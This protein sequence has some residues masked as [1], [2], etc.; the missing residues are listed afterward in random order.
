[1]GRAGSG[2]QSGES[3]KPISNKKL[4]IKHA[5]QA[6]AKMGYKL[7]SGSFSNKNK[8]TSYKVT[9]GGKSTTMTSSQIKAKIS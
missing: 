2:P 8:Q 4:T 1:M 3:K 5:S 9:K 7:G 6:L